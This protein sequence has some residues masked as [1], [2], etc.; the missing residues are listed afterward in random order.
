MKNL[1]YLEIDINDLD[2][3]RFRLKKLKHI[4]IY[5][6]FRKVFIFQIQFF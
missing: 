5:N 4:C 6:I 2:K 1:E 3:I